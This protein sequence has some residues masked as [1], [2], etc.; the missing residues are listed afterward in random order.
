M[1][2][3]VEWVLFGC[4]WTNGQICSATS[5]LLIHVSI[6]CLLALSVDSTLQI[7]WL[8]VIINSLGCKAVAFPHPATYSGLRM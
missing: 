2:T 5:R 1:Q 4:F 6:E 7:Y 3:A 8:S